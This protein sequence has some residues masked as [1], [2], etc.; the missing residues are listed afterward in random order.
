MLDAAGFRLGG[1]G[2]WMDFFDTADVVILRVR[3]RHVL[4]VELA[5]GPSPEPSQDDFDPEEEELAG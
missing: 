4:R 2:K 3:A 5:S 1:D